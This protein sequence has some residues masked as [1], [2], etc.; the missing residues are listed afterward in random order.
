MVGSIP[1]RVAC[2]PLAGRVAV[3]VAL[4]LYEDVGMGEFFV[5]VVATRRSTGTV[6]RSVHVVKYGVEGPNIQMDWFATKLSEG[7]NS[8]WVFNVMQISSFE[9][10]AFLRRQK[11]DEVLA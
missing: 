6:R 2:Y 7:F 8:D 4:S 9:Y 3:L 5:Q 11:V 10:E 1:S